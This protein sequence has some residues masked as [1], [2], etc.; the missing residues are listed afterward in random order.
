VSWAPPPRFRHFCDCEGRPGGVFRRRWKC[1]TVGTVTSG[2][3]CG[4]KENHG[5]QRSEIMLGRD[6]ESRSGLC[7]CAA[8]RVAGHRHAVGVG[9]SRG[10]SFALTQRIEGRG[11]PRPFRLGATAASQ[12]ALNPAA[13]ARPANPAQTVGGLATA[14]MLVRMKG[15]EP[16]RLSA[17]EPKSRASTNSATSARGPRIP[18]RLRHVNGVGC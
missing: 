11:S 1:R 7:S 14:L 16:P 6:G 17:L 5:R 4:D 8:S 2:L 12:C 18:R 9:G 13:A 10:L 15:L 3:R